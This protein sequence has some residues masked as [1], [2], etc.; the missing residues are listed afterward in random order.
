MP[1]KK[2]WDVS[3]I[4]G[5][6]QRLSRDCSN[7]FTDGITSFELKKD[8]YLIQEIIINALKEAPSF[9]DLEEEWLKD[10]EQKHII[11]ILK[12]R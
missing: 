4:V 3:E 2:N 10:R 8:L 9:G 6:I 12:K 11:N 5:Q 1:L 7:P